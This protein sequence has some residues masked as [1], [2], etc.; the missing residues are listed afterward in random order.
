ML[1]QASLGAQEYLQAAAGKQQHS[2]IMIRGNNGVPPH[3]TNIV[4]N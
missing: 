1:G 4:A 3:V 2:V